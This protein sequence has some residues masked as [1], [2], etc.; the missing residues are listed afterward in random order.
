MMDGPI[1]DPLSE[2]VGV[3]HTAQQDNGLFGGIP[4]LIRVTGRDTCAS[5][6]FFGGLGVRGF[7]GSGLLL[8]VVHVLGSSRVRGASP[9]GRVCGV[10][11]GGG[12]WL[13]VGKDWNL[14]VVIPISIPGRLVSLVLL[15]R[16]RRMF[17]DD[18]IVIVE[19]RIVRSASLRRTMLLP[20]AMGAL[21]RL[22]IRVT[23]TAARPS[24]IVIESETTTY[25]I[26]H[27]RLLLRAI[28][29]RE[30]LVLR[31]ASTRR[32]VRVLRRM[33]TGHSV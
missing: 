2:G 32:I 16:R 33:G 22:S 21:E 30:S 18:V 31:S 28:P 27:A 5:R 7:W 3:E 1:V 6:I 17:V 26:G 20:L 11:G 23:A 4:I 25:K 13:S 29:R 8:L 24:I 12:L 19:N 14:I 9:V 10:L 15:V